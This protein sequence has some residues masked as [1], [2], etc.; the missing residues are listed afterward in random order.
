MSTPD[1]TIPTHSPKDGVT[2]VAPTVDIDLSRSPE[3]KS[4]LRQALD[5]GTDK[6]IIDLSGVEYMDSSGLATL[7]ETMRHAKGA[8]ATLTLAGLH[9]K[10]RAI[11]EIAKLDAFFLIVDTRDE[12][13]SA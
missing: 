10:V 3:L 12:A 2:V 6:L 7:V 9:E 13:L 1:Q 8:N 5:A 4:T 11:F